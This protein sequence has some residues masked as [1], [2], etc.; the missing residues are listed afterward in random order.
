MTWFNQF[1]NMIPRG[2]KPK[3]KLQSKVNANYYC[4]L[5]LNYQSPKPGTKCRAKGSAVGWFQMV[6][7]LARDPT[8]SGPP[9]ASSIPVALPTRGCQQAA[10]G[11]LAMQ[12]RPATARPRHRSRRLRSGSPTALTMQLVGSGSTLTPWPFAPSS[13]AWHWWR[14][15]CL[16]SV[17]FM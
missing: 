7:P 4:F 11:P 2:K 10:A 9:I 6:Q 13:L 12:A 3:K 14:L 1:W 5:V 17:S 16:P 8:R 15:Q